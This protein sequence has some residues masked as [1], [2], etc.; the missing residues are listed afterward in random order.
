M[1]FVRPLRNIGEKMRKWEFRK[2]DSEIMFLEK[3]H[4]FAESAW[5]FVK[6]NAIWWQNWV[7]PLVGNLGSCLTLVTRKG[8]D[9]DWDS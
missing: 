8:S 9:P 1:E 3:K 4:H 2:N 6:Y 5:N 7:E